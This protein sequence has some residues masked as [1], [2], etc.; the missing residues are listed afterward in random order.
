[1]TTGHRRSPFAA[2]LPALLL[3][4]GA[5]SSA[6]AQSLP[7]PDHT[8]V[9]ILE[10][11]SYSEIIGNNSAPYINSLRTQG[12]NFTDSHAVSHP[13]EPNYLALFQG[14]TEGLSDDSC[15][16]EY[17][18]PNLGSGLLANGQTFAGFSESMPYDGYTGCG[19]GDYA[20][21]HNAWVDFTDLPSTVNRVF[22]DFPSDYTRLPTVAYVAPNLCSD[23]HDCSV[24]TGDA[25]LESRLGDYVSWA[26]THNSL[27][28]LTFDEDAN[29]TSTNQIATL[30]V[31]PMVQPGDDSTPIDHYAVLR[32]LEDMY[33][34]PPTGNATLAAPITDI[35]QSAFLPPA[36][37]AQIPPTKPPTR[38]TTAVRR[39]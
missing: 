29:D 13:S 21:K 15:P 33:G 16:H 3:A 28:I 8:V 25:W 7:R 14:T 26:A 27:L 6:A 4:S 5:P 20:R 30:F 9:V 11:H 39:P 37:R 23:M 12:A 2:A 18:D 24:A 17:S 22:A 32:T 34:V 35:W 1:V 36:P 10:N 38:R 31:G 19:S